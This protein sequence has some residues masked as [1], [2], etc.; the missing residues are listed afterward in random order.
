MDAIDEMYMCALMA[1][2]A[3]DLNCEVRVTRC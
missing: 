3:A 1:I 2:G